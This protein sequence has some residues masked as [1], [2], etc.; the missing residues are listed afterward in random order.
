M[1]RDGF[2]TPG[3]GSVKPWA[4]QERSRGEIRHLREDLQRD[5]GSGIRRN[6]ETGILP[7][8]IW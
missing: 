5:S 3:G 1:T 6:G 7:P 2:F 4:A 8:R